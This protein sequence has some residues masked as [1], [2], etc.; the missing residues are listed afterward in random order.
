RTRW[1]QDGSWLQFRSTSF[2]DDR[3][4]EVPNRLLARWSAARRRN[5]SLSLDELIEI[6]QLPD[7][8]LD[9]TEMAEGARDCW[10]LAE[11][12]LPRSG[13]L[14]A[15][16]RYLAAFTADERQE[17]R[18]PAGLPFSKMS[19]AQQQ[20]FL[21]RLRSPEPFQWPEDLTGATLRV[22]FTQPGWFTWRVP[23]FLGWIAPLKPVE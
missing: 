15:G 4:K 11:G 22:Q 5:G 14:R 13:I 6:A 17:M 10:G 7:A 2:Y 16:L 9:G 1:N 3:R 18:T 8:Q 19:L 23:G 12:R 20:G 21:A